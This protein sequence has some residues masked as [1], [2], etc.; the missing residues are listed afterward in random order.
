M[1]ISIIG[2]GYVGLPIAIEFSKKY[3]TIG[4]DINQQRV[5]QLKANI[6]INQD[7]VVHPDNIQASMLED[8]TGWS[9]QSEI[10][11][12]F[13]PGP[14]AHV[15]FSI[16]LDKFHFDIYAKWRDDQKPIIG[17]NAYIN[18]RREDIKIV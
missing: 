10:K 1:K 11:K 13:Y 15:L 9:L 18:I 4:F 17:K 2:L 3:P 12:V 6:D 7:I 5:K 8:K 14:S 16:M